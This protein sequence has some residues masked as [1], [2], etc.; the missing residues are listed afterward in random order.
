MSSAFTLRVSRSD[1]SM[2]VRASCICVRRLSAP[3][4]VSRWFTNA[5][6]VLSLS[7][8]VA[9]MWSALSN[10]DSENVHTRK[11]FNFA[12]LSPALTFQVSRVMR[13]DVSVS[14]DAST[15]QYFVSSWVIEW[16]PN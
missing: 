9:S 2:P 16:I 5:E 6:G 10:L 4:K 1:T 3:S 15:Y 7:S 11:S 12:Y 14:R 8:L 13:E